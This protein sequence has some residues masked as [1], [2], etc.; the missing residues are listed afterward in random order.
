MSLSLNAVDLMEIQQLGGTGT[1][2]C[3]WWDNIFHLKA[4]PINLH[5]VRS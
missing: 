5:A 3:S 1:G 2:D 4:A